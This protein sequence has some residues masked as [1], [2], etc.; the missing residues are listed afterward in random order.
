VSKQPQ[1]SVSIKVR[2]TT[3]GRPEPPS[4]LVWI[5]DYKPALNLY[6]MLFELRGFNVLTASTGDE[7]L[8]LVAANHVD[9]VVTDYE[10]PGMDGEAVATSVKHIHPKLPVILF[11]GSSCIP[12][13]VET[14]V[15]AICDK[16]GAR[17]EL[18]AVIHRLVGKELDQPFV[19]PQS[20]LHPATSSLSV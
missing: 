4:T 10:M 9:A 16:T 19:P 18:L 6:K 1:G 20:G 5:D 8:R 3:T 17:E 15:D 11:S 7:G 14:V 13:R 2:A 12:A